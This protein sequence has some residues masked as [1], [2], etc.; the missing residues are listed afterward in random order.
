MAEPKAEDIRVE[1]V[2]YL[3][4][5]R[6]VYVTNVMWRVNGK[7]RSSRVSYQMSKVEAEAHAQGHAAKEK[8]E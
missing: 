5:A 3:D 1:Y 6:T 8:T 4:G 7:A 2:P